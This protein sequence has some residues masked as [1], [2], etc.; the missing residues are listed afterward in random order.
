MVVKFRQY[1]WVMCLVQID[2]MS[3]MYDLNTF[4]LNCIIPVLYPPS[5][6]TFVDPRIIYQH[7]TISPNYQPNS[8]MY[9]RKATN[10]IAYC[11]IIDISTVTLLDLRNWTF[12]AINFIHYILIRHVDQI[13]FYVLHISQKLDQGVEGL[14]EDGDYNMEWRIRCANQSFQSQMMS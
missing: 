12:I 3:I 2:T 10:F 14:N 7:P 8:G 1:K 6:F 5:T 13:M 9:N 11:W 4:S